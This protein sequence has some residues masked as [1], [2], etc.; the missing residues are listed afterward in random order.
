M[1]AA[2]RPGAWNFPLF[3]HVLG[4]MWLFGA[5]LAAL[6]LA[7][8]GRSRAA[9]S[10]LLVAVPGWVVGFAGANWIA[11]KEHLENSNATWI[12]IGHVALDFGVVLLL[13][14]LGVSFWWKRSGKARAGQITAALCSI[15]L[16]LLAIAWL[17]MSGKW[18]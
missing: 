11:S 2:I 14:A 16:L 5:V 12:N 13:A 7:R 3:L 1:I 8:A 9:F 15:Y 6:V 17:A 10:S 18:S 4:V